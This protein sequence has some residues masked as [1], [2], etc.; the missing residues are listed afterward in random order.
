M[1]A[2]DPL[3]T[4]MALQLVSFQCE[5]Q[6]ALSI[7]ISSSSDSIQYEYRLSQRQLG[8]KNIDTVS[9]Y[10]HQAAT[11]VGG[12]M[13]GEIEVSSQIELSWITH[14]EL[15]Q[16]CFWYNNI[17]IQIKIDPKI[18]IAREHKKGTCEHNAVHNHE[19]KH[20]N[21]DRRLVSKYQNIIYFKGFI[22]CNLY[23]IWHIN[24]FNR[25]Q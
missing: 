3:V 23:W 20:V 6:P 25:F 2:F 9:P 21:V 16:N 24:S 19:L 11:V 1:L 4:A 14:R 5:S 8:N 18:Y 12:L 7:N 22:D 10:G 17:D 15:Q 13:S